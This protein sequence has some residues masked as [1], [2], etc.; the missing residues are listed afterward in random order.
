MGVRLT[1][2][3]RLGGTMS[4]DQM[5]AM[6]EAMLAVVFSFLILSIFFIYQF[7]TYME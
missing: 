5:R 4:L 7:Y 2:L 1:Q 6:H 3:D